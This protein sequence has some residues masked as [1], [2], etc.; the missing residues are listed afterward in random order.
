MMS[1]LGSRTTVNVV[2]KNA[3]TVIHVFAVQ[4]RL[5]D[6]PVQSKKESALQRA[7]LHLLYVAPRQLSPRVRTSRQI[8][9]ADRNGETIAIGLTVKRCTSSDR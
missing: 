7:S 8:S 5:Y 9:D 3:S 4:T 2:K 6:A 1:Y